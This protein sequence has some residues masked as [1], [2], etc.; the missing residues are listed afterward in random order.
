[1]NAQIAVVVG[2]EQEHCAVVGEASA[3]KVVARG[4]ER[5]EAARM[6]DLVALLAELVRADDQAHT[7]GRTEALGD[8]GPK[9]GDIGVASLPLMHAASHRGV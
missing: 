3:L 4:E 2:R 9:L 6:H 1:M 8:V 7:V 5:N